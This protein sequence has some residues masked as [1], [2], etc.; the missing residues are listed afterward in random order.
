MNIRL[1]FFYLSMILIS[2]QLFSQT[3]FVNQGAAGSGDGSSWENAY[4]SLSDALMAHEAG[5]FWIAKGTYTHP[6]SPSNLSNTFLISGPVNLYGGF[7]G[8][9]VSIDERI[10]SENET[11]LSG[12]VASNDEIGE[13]FNKKSDN[14]FHVITIKSVFQDT[15]VLDGLTISGGHTSVDIDDEEYTRRGGGLFSYNSI[16]VNN[17]KFQGNFANSGASIYI[18]S[19]GGYGSGSSIKNSTFIDN[20]SDARGAGIYFIGLSDILLENNNFSNNQ[21][22]RGCVYPFDSDDIRIINNTFSNNVSSSDDIFTTGIFSALTT[23]VRMEGCTFTNNMAP[24]AAAIYFEGDGIP[25]QDNLVMTGC[26]FSGNEATDFGGADLYFW[27]AT[28]VE[29]SN[30]TFTGAK[31]PNGGVMYSDGRNTPLSANNLVFTKCTFSGNEAT[32]FGGG[33]LYSWQGGMT[34]DSCTFDGNIAFGGAGFYFDNREKAGLGLIVRQSEFRDNTSPYVDGIGGAIRVNQASLNVTNSVFT[35]NQCDN[36]ASIFVFADSASVNINTNDFVGGDGKFGGALACY[37]YDSDFLLENLLFSDNSASASGGAIIAGFGANSRVRNCQFLDNYGGDG[38]AVRVQNDSTR[39]TILE[40]EFSANTSDGDGGGILLSGGDATVQDC[41]FVDNVAENGGGIASY[42][43]IGLQMPSTLIVFDSKFS[44]NVA[45]RKGGA[46]DIT[47]TDTEIR[48][49]LI[50]NNSNFEGL[51]GGG[52]AI[53]ASDSS[54]MVVEVLN[55][56]ISGNIAEIGH[57]IG[58][59][60]DENGSELELILR[61]TIVA[62]EGSNVEIQEGTPTITSMGGNVLSDESLEAALTG[63]QDKNN[64][65]GQIFVDYTAQDYHLID[66]SLAINI[67]QGEVPELDLDGLPRVNTPDAG[68]FEY[69]LDVNVED[70]II[71]NNGEL[72]V[73]PNPV[74]DVL[75]FRFD[76]PI[77]GKVSV[78]IINTEGR[79]V[80]HNFYTKSIGQPQQQINISDLNSGIYHLIVGTRDALFATKVVVVD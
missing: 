64:V 53:N 71:G 10:L 40:C 8:T 65:L 16:A 52:V 22:A 23:N 74:R 80:L 32:D 34:L 18:S 19:E 29:I 12:D 6:I 69:Q 46:V 72:V 79:V 38:G 15:F 44:N 55:T 9:E 48:N 27:Q 73:I 56:T 49:S 43:A 14:S 41:N 42:E 60:E 5:D 31:A 62:N 35:D 24:N 45:T 66:G 76:H 54:A 50:S 26:T 17:C 78:M 30:C 20:R 59:F 63:V 67:A 68:A 28:G 61:N 11:I 33:A 58:L 47:D 2:S 1:L 70:L 57:G 21:A 13:F 4:L 37:G 7:A 77:D 51:L 39:L 75:N 36:G 3:I 25:S